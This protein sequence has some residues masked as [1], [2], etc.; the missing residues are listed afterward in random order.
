MPE[1]VWLMGIFLSLTIGYVTG[2][3][4]GCWS[5][6][7]APNAAAWENV[8]KFEIVTKQETAMHQMDLDHEAEMALI[9]RGVYDSIKKEEED[10]EQ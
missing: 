1:W 7:K 3:L 6:E 10:D 4:G 8:K 9:E 5:S 2:F